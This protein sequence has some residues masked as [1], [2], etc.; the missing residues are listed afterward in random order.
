MATTISLTIT[1]T[2]WHNINEFE[3]SSEL[4]LNSVY[5]MQINTGKLYVAPNNSKPK[6]GVIGILA[7]PADGI[8]VRYN[9]TFWFRV[10]P[11]N[12]IVTIA[13]VG[14]TDDNI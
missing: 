3:D 2:N 12:A 8:N 9:N 14:G 13:E 4:T 7:S 10:L 6:K 1:D 5:L 11:A